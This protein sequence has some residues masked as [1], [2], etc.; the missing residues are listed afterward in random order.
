MGLVVSQPAPG[1][2]RFC[3]VY[4][5]WYVLEEGGRLTVLDGGLP[6]DRSAFSSALSGLGY[7][8]SDIEAVLLTH[9]HPD[10]VGNAEHL[11]RNGA[12][13]FSHPADAPFVRGETRM[14]TAA[15]ARYLL[16]PWYASYMLRLLA[17]GITRVAPVTELYGMTDGEV[18]DIP[19][20]PRVVHTPGH[21]AGSC[22]LLLEQGSVLFSGDALV[23]SDVTRGK[24]AG[25][26][27]IR[28]PVTEDAEL[29]VAS[30]ETLVRTRARTVL[31]GHGEP[32]VHGIESAVEIAQKQW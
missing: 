1:V 23:T 19:G 9:H 18:L 31:P 27:T 10:H 21:T 12:R 4:T 11:R 32:W 20:S 17:K 13:V 24:R 22:S 16:N 5:N 26:Q 2:F 7:L 25:P 29:A 28:G 3:S 8:S 15:H 30:L 14:S 6:G